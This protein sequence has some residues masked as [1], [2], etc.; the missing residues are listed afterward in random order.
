MEDLENEGIS[1]GDGYVVK[2]QR[3]Q[4]IDPSKG[5]T[6][7]QEFPNLAVDVGKRK[8]TEDP[9]NQPNKRLKTSESIGESSSV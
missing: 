8:A 6:T 9:T 5:T 3:R 4:I 2:P 1:L 7:E